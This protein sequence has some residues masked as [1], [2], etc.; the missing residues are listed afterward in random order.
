VARK[1]ADVKVKL[2]EVKIALIEVLAESKE[3]VSLA[4]LPLYL[5]KKVHFPLDWN[6]LGFAK[7]KD[8][9]KTMSDEIKIDLKGHN[10]PLAYLINP[11]HG[12]YSSDSL[13]QP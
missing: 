7:L 9:I 3:G 10:H 2:K 11:C 6:S 12:R 13:S 4:Q 5:Q 8:F 1:R